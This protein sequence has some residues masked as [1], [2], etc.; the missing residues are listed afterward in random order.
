M[1]VLDRYES[2][3]YFR[4]LIKADLEVGTL[5]LAAKVSALHPL[6]CSITDILPSPPKHKMPLLAGWIPSRGQRVHLEG[7]VPVRFL[8]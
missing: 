1:I 5:K 7:R 3:E 8:A 2:V 4:Q 6:S